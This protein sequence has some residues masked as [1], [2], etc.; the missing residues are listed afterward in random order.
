MA[1]D[2]FSYYYLN[3]GLS[4]DILECYID[5][6]DYSGGVFPVESGNPI[7]YIQN[8]GPTG[9]IN[10]VP[11]SGGLS[12]NIFEINS[13]NSLEKSDCSF[14]LIFEKVTSGEQVLVSTL[15]QTAAGTSGFVLG[16]NDSNRLFVSCPHPLGYFETYSYEFPLARKNGI[17][18][19]KDNNNFSLVKFNFS[20]KRI[21]EERGTFP[22][23]CLAD[24]LGFFIGGV[25]GSVDGFQSNPFIGFIDEFAFVSDIVNT[26]NISGIFKGM[27]S[28]YPEMAYIPLFETS[29][30][31]YQGLTTLSGVEFNSLTSGALDYI[32]SNIFNITGVG[33]VTVVSSGVVTSNVAHV[34]GYLSGLVSLPTG[35][36]YTGSGQYVTGYTTSGQ[37]AVA[38]GITG[39]IPIN[40]NPF[41]A[42]DNDKY[43]LSGYSGITGVT[44]WQDVFTGPLYGTYYFTGFAASGLNTFYYFPF[45]FD[46]SGMS[47]HAVYNHTAKY[48]NNGSDRI[49]VQQD[50]NYSGTVGQPQP[51]RVFKTTQIDFGSG[52]VEIAPNDSF[53]KTFLMDGVTLNEPPNSG[54]ISEV[55]YQEF[56]GY[57]RFNEDLITD[58]SSGYFKTINSE[59]SGLVSA[60]ANGKHLLEKLDEYLFLVDSSGNYIVDSSG[61]FITVG[62][63][64]TGEFLYSDNYLVSDLSYDRIDVPVLD[65]FSG[66]SPTQ[67]SGITAMNSGQILYSGDSSMIFING[68]K[69]VSGVDFT[70]SGTSHILMTNQYSGIEG[71][72]WVINPTYS[73]FEY[74]KLSGL[75]TTGNFPERSS[76]FYLNGLRQKINIDYVETSRHDLVHNITGEFST[77]FA[78]IFETENFV[79]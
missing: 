52:F 18:V 71:D 13:G 26:S 43:L 20:E 15:S 24:G 46:L 27:A 12:G 8:Y 51:F 64:S 75:S 66:A 62:S 33:T 37:I 41:A 78:S 61:N 70:I 54:S 5:F 31:K 28:A 77:E 49:L 72:L 65:I 44:Q 45:S 79:I 47:G 10:Q 42:W 63:V 40:L 17:A 29:D 39:Y 55:L 3:G 38:T 9:I 57:Y 22:N 2:G 16:V 59:E 11:G 34:S 76:C 32:Q 36:F 21:Y 67:F 6:T 35:Y 68:Q 74:L 48:T 69:L 19:V 1:L 50:L 60:Y 7:Y 58:Y 14:F 25:T 56:S 4:P 53:C 30:Y 23:E 73:I